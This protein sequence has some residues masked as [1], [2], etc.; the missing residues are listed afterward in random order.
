MVYH[1]EVLPAL[2]VAGTVLRANV[3]LWQYVL[4]VKMRMLKTPCNA[5]LP[6]LRH[7]Q[8]KYRQLIN[9]C[10]GY[11]KRILLREYR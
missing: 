2:T 9:H 8:M 3:L 5:N 4:R 6:V 11:Q 7:E 10:F 1:S